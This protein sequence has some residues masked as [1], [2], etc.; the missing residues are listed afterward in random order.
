VSGILRAEF[1]KL[2]GSRIPWICSAGIAALP[3]AYALVG[4]ASRW[5]AVGWPW[6]LF[7]A[8]NLTLIL[9]IV[10]PVLLGLLASH[11]FAR[12]FVEGTASNLFATPVNRDSILAAKFIVLLVWSLFPGL[13]AFLVSV[14]L[15]L[16]I[17]LSGF[18]WE[19]LRWAFPRYALSG[20][21]MYLTVPLAALISMVTREY[22]PPMVF[23][24]LATSVAVID[25]TRIAIF[26]AF[27]LGLRWPLLGYLT[28]LA[29]VYPYSLPRIIVFGT[30]RDL[31]YFGGHLASS[32]AEFWVLLGT[33]A[34]GV[35][36]NVLYLR[37]AQIGK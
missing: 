36:L 16:C 32:A 17:G 26:L 1:L 13:L 27:L 10:G 15:G 12:E 11:I 2:K 8:W 33:F 34:I 22:V 31:D 30:S 5:G 18:S 23:T 20:L 21:L 28:F 24:I 25:P 9:Y 7:L 14:P 3:C 4:L 19:V 29:Q 6:E 35:L 37:K